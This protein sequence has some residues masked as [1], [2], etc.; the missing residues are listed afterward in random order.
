MRRDTVVVDGAAAAPAAPTAAPHAPVTDL[1]W[2]ACAPAT[3]RAAALGQLQA[4]AGNA[5]IA[6]TL[7]RPVGPP[8]T[9]AERDDINALIPIE[10]DIDALVAAV[11]AG[12][13]QWRGWREKL[14]GPV[15]GAE[16]FAAFGAFKAAIRA[17]GFDVADPR[18][19][20]ALRHRVEGDHRQ[21]L[22]ELTSFALG[23]DSGRGGDA[24]GLAMACGIQAK[25]LK[26]RYTLKIAFGLT[27][28]GELPGVGGLGATVRSASVVYSND[29]GMSYTKPLQMR[30]AVLSGGGAGTSVLS[31]DGAAEGKDESLSYWEPDEFETGFSL[32]KLAAGGAAIGKGEVKFHE[33]VRVASDRHPPLL[34]DLMAGAPVDTDTGIEGG[35]ELGAGAE[36][37][38]GKLVGGRDVGETTV[39]VPTLQGAEE[40]AIRN[41]LIPENRD[42]KWWVIGGTVVE[43]ATGSSRIEGRAVDDVQRFADSIGAWASA[44]PGGE[45]R[46]DIVGRASPRWRH[47][48][49]GRI[50]DDLNLKLSQERADHTLGAVQ[51][52]LDAS[53]LATYQAT[54]VMG[55]ELDLDDDHAQASGHGALDAV[56]EGAGPENDDAGHRLA[57]VTA[58]GKKAPPEPAPATPL[59]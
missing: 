47:P 27:G 10:G 32:T 43:F 59:P 50:P 9:Q 38:A 34:F 13:A 35:R 49:R 18:V 45:V 55:P 30:S 28:K 29:F 46:F 44:N 1:A 17:K 51:R 54:G 4:S 37:E 6:R 56:A 14:V 21:L 3:T 11:Q 20:E 26:H 48:K 15:P 42:Q 8:A 2:L 36:I 16:T 31:R 58:W 53:V 52:A 33:A 12:C 25:V 19:Q 41:K 39:H 40:E 7:E 23:T 24:N 22:T 5:L 57:T